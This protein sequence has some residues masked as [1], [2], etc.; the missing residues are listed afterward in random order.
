MKFALYGND[1]DDTTNPIEA[2][3]GWVVKPE[4]SVEFIGREHVVSVKQRGPGRKLIGFVLN[5]KGIP[6]TGCEIE[7][8]GSIVGKV[9]SGTH[10]PSLDQGIGMGYVAA[11]YAKPGQAIN[12]VIRGNSLPAT[13]IKPPFVP[14][15]SHK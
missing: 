12:I 9:T 15:T 13:I 8:G 5:A 4:K 10:S 6:R 3:L 11:Q 14:N 7:A 1:I 2:G